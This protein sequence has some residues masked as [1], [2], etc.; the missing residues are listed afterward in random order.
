[1]SSIHTTED[2]IKKQPSIFYYLMESS[3]S[4]S[5]KL[6][7]DFTQINNWMG[8]VTRMNLLSSGDVD[9]TFYAAD[10]VQR[11]EMWKSLK[12]KQRPA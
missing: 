10:A 4:V 12:G 7:K 11:S 1:M 9:Q 6:R 5:K 3:L 8:N 2:L